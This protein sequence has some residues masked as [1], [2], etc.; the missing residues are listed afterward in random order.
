MTKF[1][2]EHDDT[3][4]DLPSTFLLDEFSFGVIHNTK[5]GFLEVKG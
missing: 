5:N 1:H 3:Y 4:C 2:E